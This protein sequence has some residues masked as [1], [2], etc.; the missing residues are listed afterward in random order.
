ME[1]GSPAISGMQ[2]NN[3]HDKNAC[4]SIDEQQNDDGLA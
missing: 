2:S 1:R 4:H 3:S